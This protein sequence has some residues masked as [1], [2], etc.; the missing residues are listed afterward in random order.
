[1]RQALHFAAG[2]NVSKRDFIRQSGDKLVSAG[3]E[4]CGDTA[5]A[6][7]ETG[8]NQKTAVGERLLP[9]GR[10][11]HFLEA[12]GRT[13]NDGLRSAQK[14]AETFLFYGRM[15]AADDAAASFAPPDNLV[16]GG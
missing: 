4:T 10:K 3:G 16:V 13:D 2:R 9:V 15:E 8:E 12:A 6:F 7:G 14:D 5:V 1:M 11:A